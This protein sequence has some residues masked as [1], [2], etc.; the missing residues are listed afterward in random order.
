MSPVSYFPAAQVDSR[1]GEELQ[2]FVR[3]FCCCWLVVQCTWLQQPAHP[4][5]THLCNIHNSWDGSNLQ[6]LLCTE[7]SCI[8]LAIFLWALL[9]A[10]EV[11]AIFQTLKL[12]EQHFGCK[13]SLEGWEVVLLA[14]SGSFQDV[15][16]ELSH[17]DG[18][19]GFWRG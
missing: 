1:E 11:G 5:R 12:S 18:R 13:V 6:G 16:S 4:S 7:V 14:L 10:A 9:V 17:V 19:K 8:L 15:K 2:R 3:C